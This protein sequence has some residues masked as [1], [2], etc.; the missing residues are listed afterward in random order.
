[1][2]LG[3]TNLTSLAN[4]GVVYSLGT[5]RVDPQLLESPSRDALIAKVLA[6]QVAPRIAAV[7]SLEDYE[8]QRRQQT[9]DANAKAVAILVRVKGWSEPRALQ[10]VHAWLVGLNMRGTP[11]R[12]GQPTPC[13]QIV[14][15]LARFPDQQD[16]TAGLSCGPGP[17]GPRIPTSRS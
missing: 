4:V 17:Q 8:R 1:M 14:D 11:P 9:L 7:E 2:R 6:L 10:S 15:L 13:E 5:L 3:S 16:W 12:D